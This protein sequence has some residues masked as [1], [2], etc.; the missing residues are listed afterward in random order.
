MGKEYSMCDANDGAESG[1]V[2]APIL[3]KIKSLLKEIGPEKWIRAGEAFDPSVLC[4]KALQSWEQVFAMVIPTG[5]LAIRSSRPV[6]SKFIRGGYAL[7]AKEDEQFTVELRASGWQPKE[8]ID[9]YHRTGALKERPYSTLAEGRFARELFLH[10]RQRFEEYRKTAQQDLAMKVED[11]VEKTLTSRDVDGKAWT[12]TPLAT[13]SA[14]YCCHLDS[15]ELEV[16]SVLKDEFPCYEMQAKS[17]GIQF[18]MS[19]NR[20]VQDLYLLVEEA[21]RLAQLQTLSSVLEG[22]LGQ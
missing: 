11:F 3:E 20:R 4:P 19:S 15:I 17:G 10:V 16:S 12:W 21:V 22:E 7:S 2:E 6:Q 8:L 1:E 5:T 9:P 18:S 14:K 13:R